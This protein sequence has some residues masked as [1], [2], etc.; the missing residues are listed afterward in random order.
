MFSRIYY[1]GYYTGSWHAADWESDAWLKAE[2][3]KYPLVYAKT[4]DGIKIRVL[5]K[6]KLNKQVKIVCEILPSSQ[7]DENKILTKIVAHACERDQHSIAAET[8]MALAEI[9][10]I[11]QLQLPVNKSSKEL[12]D[13]L[14]KVVYNRRKRGLGS[15]GAASIFGTVF[16]GVGY[17][18]K[19]VIDAALGT[20][21]YARKEDLVKV[22]HEM[23]SLR[24][25]QVQ[26]QQTNAKVQ[27]ALHT[28]ESRLMNVMIG[29]TSMYIEAEI[30]SLN[31]HLQSILGLTLLKYSAALQMAQS[32]K[33]HPYALSQAELINLSTQYFSTHKIHLDTDTKNV[34]T[35]FIIHNNTIFFLFSIPIIQQEK[36]FHFYTLVPIPTFAH[37]STL[38]PDIDTDNIAISKN[39]DKFT[40]L[41]PAEIEN[42]LDEPPICTSNKP[43]F[44]MS[45]QALC[46]VSTYTTS[47]AKCPLKMTATKPQPFLHFQ[48]NQLFF[49]VPS[50]ITAYVKCQQSSASNEYTEKTISL[51]GIGQGEYKSSCTINLPDGTSYRTPSDKVVT[52]IQDWPIFQLNKLLPLDI[53]TQINVPNMYTNFTTDQLHPIT[54]TT[55]MLGDY[56][57]SDAINGT[58]NVLISIIVVT[59]MMKALYYKLKIRTNNR[60]FT[61]QA[62]KVEKEQQFWYKHNESPLEGSPELRTAHL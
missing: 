12:H 48:G 16:G 45:N 13:F 36:V 53:D 55:D 61:D 32:R 17:V 14:P 44:P 59:T 5:D 22:A 47:S 34:Q 37:N 49:S 29:T 31:R 52:K 26:I 3:R 25:N 30:K 57:A 50:P 58:I 4:D 35:T 19:S 23:D 54:K 42:C 38:W 15:L 33:T 6:D 8:Q 1:G 18:L 21:K 9:L 27:Q 7:A 60:N 62:H 2:I 28:L 11:T 20:N 41:T 43:V 39:G 51:Q 40:T 46:V 10:T 56:T 24:I